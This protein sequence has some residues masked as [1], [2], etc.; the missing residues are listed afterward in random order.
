MQILKQVNIKDCIFLDIET[1]RAEST[2]D[3]TKEDLVLN[4]KYKMRNE[5]DPNFEEL[6]LNKAPLYAEFGKICCIS[7]GMEIEGEFKKFSFAKVD[8]KEL[9][10]QFVTWIDRKFSQNNNTKVIGHTHKAFDIPFIMRRC[11]V[12]ELSIPTI[13]DTAHMKPWE[14]NFLIDIAELWKSTS[15]ASTNL[16]NICYALGIESPKIDIDGGQVSDYYFNGKIEEIKK[17]CE[18]DVEKTYEIFLRLKN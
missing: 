17:Y 14:Q 9:L 13:C 5:V 15:Y 18:K 10:M 7:V 1:V 16:T 11:I 8:E 4:W 2:Y 3:T 6:Y 12:H